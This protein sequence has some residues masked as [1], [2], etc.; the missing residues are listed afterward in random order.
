LGGTL[1]VTNSGSLSGSGTLSSVTVAGGGS[2][3]PGNSPGTLT[4]A[5]TLSLN[6]GGIL[7]WEIS[8]WTGGAG[9]ASG[10]DLINVQTLQLVNSNNSGQFTINVSGL[11]SVTNFSNVS[12]NFVFLNATNGL[13]SFNTGYFTVNSS[14]F[15]NDGATGSWSVVSSNNSLLLSYT[16]PLPQSN[17]VW[18]TNSGSW[19]TASNWTNNAVPS[20]TVNLT[21]TGSGGSSTNNLSG[22]TATGITFA[23]NAGSYTLSGSNLVLS[24]TILNSSSNS[25]TMSNNMALGSASS[26]NA[27]SNIKKFIGLRPIFSILASNSK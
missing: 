23:T 4:V 25:Q 16:V 20:D 22:I 10:W 8:N 5:N 18:A 11:G 19:G 26:L 27:A 1:T 12:T 17:F 24:G 6:T 21:F 13:P 7:N 14:G 9:L 3:N 15:T 2:I